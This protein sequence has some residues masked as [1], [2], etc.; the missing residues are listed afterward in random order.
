MQRE[1]I[2]DDLRH[3]AF[4][5]FYWFSRFE[6]ALKENRILKSDTPGD[7]AE[8]GWRV[9]I[10]TYG[11]GW[12]PTPAAAQLIAEKPQRQIVTTTGLDFRDLSFNTGASELERAVRYAQ[13]VRNNLFHGGKH[14]GSYWDDPRRM[15]RLL[16][17]TITVLDDFAQLAGIE[18][19]YRR[20]Y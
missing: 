3:L 19:D 8:P 10:E 5:F 2:P 6:F 9:F 12:M 16:S 17:A 11:D 1:E 20:L 14:G 7:N 18:G 13:T 15:R 4:D